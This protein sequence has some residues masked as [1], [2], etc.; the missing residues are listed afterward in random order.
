[1]LLFL[2]SGHGDKE[3]DGVEKLVGLV[4]LVGLVE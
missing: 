2:G 1:M 3:S 4:G